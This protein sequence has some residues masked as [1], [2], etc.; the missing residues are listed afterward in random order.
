[1]SNFFTTWREGDW[2]VVYEYFEESSK[3]YSLYN[4]VDDPSESN[5]LAAA[6]RN[7]LQRMMQ[8]M[9]RE[10]E[11]MDAVYPV[12]EGNALRPILP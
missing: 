6:H 10:L 8:G 1:V 12:K 11:S 2:K 9:V 4:L 3:R 7:E 5:N